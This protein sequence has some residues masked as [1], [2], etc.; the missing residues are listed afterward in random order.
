MPFAFHF[1]ASVLS[2]FLIVQRLVLTTNQMHFKDIDLIW[3]IRNCNPELT[4]NTPMLI[5]YQYA[6]GGA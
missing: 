1:K 3:G 5:F 2:F 6:L 4:L